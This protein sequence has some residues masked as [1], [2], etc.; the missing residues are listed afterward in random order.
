[1][2]SLEQRI[3]QAINAL[4]AGKMIMVKDD[5]DREGEGDLI[6]AASTMDEPSMAF[7]IRHTSGII[8]APLTRS[9]AK[10]L[11]LHEMVPDHNNDTPYQTAFTISIDAK[12]NLT[13]GISAKERLTAVQMLANKK[14]TANDFVKPGHIFPLIAKPGGVLTRSGHTEAAVDLMLL[15]HLP[16]VGVIGEL[17]NDDGTVK[18]GNDLISFANKHH[19]VILTI[20]DI[21]AHRQGREQLLTLK[22]KK[23][24]V[25]NVAGKSLT[26]S[27]FIY[28]TIFDDIPHYAL[29]FG[30]IDSDGKIKNNQ[31]IMTRLH[32]ENLPDDIFGNKHDLEKAIKMLVKESASQASVLIYL[33]RGTVGVATNNHEVRQKA[34]REIGVGAQI[35]KHLG[36]EKINLL[37]HHEKQY[38][39]LSGFGLVI[40]KFTQF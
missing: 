21:I 27:L 1:M 8:C 4:K 40:E 14:S 33:R 36:V 34:W 11:G 29:V 9:R 12:K 3:K 5:D 22:N 16:D 35:L 6:A 7:M 13:T 19:L 24:I 10:N 30:K 28:Q 38:L 25:M 20:D 2:E 26:A 18:K 23:P 37:A 32:I 31:T 17:I 15:A 39:G